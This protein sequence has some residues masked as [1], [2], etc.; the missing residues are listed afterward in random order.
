M[1]SASPDDS[2]VI[3]TTT[4]ETAAQAEQLAAAI[5]QQ[6][7]AACVQIDGPI[8][9]HYVW[10][11]AVQATAEWRLTIKTLRWAARQ[12]Q[13]QL[14]TLHP[15]ELPQWVVVAAGDASPE[16]LEWVRQAVDAPAAAFHLYLYGPQRG[17]LP[18]AFEP[19]LERLQAQPRVHAELDGSFVW[20]TESGQIDGMV[21]DLGDAVQYLELKGNCGWSQWSQ[22]IQ[23]LAPSEAHNPTGERAAATTDWQVWLIREQRLQDLQSFEKVCWPLAAS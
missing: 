23:W 12:L 15:Y 8:T 16:Y 9:S 11:G 4:V 6:R 10:Q 13:Q 21:Y 22:L 2:L 5:I 7:L 1:P 3:A 18:I 14:A 19:L 17:P 20:V